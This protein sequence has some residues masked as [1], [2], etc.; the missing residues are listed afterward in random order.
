[1]AW[2][3]EARKRHGLSILNYMVTSNHVHL[4]V[5][6]DSDR[7]AIPEIGTLLTN[8]TNPSLVKHRGQV[9]IIDIY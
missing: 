1:V 4:L 2:L 3:F 6:G 8:C 7:D 5:S 9:F